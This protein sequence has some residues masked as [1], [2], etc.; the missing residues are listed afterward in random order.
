MDI[1]KYLTEHQVTQRMLAKTLGVT[2]SAVSQWI[3]GTTEPTGR[4]AANIIRITHGEVTLDDL[5]P[6]KKAA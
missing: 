3:S 5:Y 6:P 2:P 4:Q 1:K